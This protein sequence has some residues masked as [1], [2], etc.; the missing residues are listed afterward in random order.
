M[1]P[2]RGRPPKPSP[3]PGKRGRHA[4]EEDRIERLAI[5]ETQRAETLANDLAHAQAQRELDIQAKARSDVRAAASR[6][7]SMSK[8]ESRREAAAKRKARNIAAVAQ[9]R[10]RK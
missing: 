5:L 4:L 8:R 2:K 9:G 7:A 3:N 1:P 6:S 10:L